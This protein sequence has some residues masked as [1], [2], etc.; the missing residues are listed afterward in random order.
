MFKHRIRGQCCM[1][2]CGCIKDVKTCNDVQSFV[3]I[4]EKNTKYYWEK[5]SMTQ[6]FNRKLGKENPGKNRLVSLISILG[7]WWNS[8][9][10][11]PFPGTWRTAANIVCVDINKAFDTHFCTGTVPPN[12]R[13]HFLLLCRWHSAGIGCPGM[14]WGLHAWR[15]SKTVWMWF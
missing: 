3:L 11:K 12:I 5:F 15:Y 7:R 2:L 8:S 4:S 14:L 13:K 9:S 10:L 1:Y 6:Y